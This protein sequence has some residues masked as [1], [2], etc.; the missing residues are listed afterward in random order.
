MSI[1]H[2]GQVFLGWSTLSSGIKSW[3]WADTVFTKRGTTNLC[4][5][6]ELFLKSL[7]VLLGKDVP[8]THK[9][10]ELANLLPKKELETV[11]TAYAKHIQQPSFDML[12]SEISQFFVKL[13]YEYEF[14]IFS[15]N[16]YAV[17]VF[18]DALYQHCAIRNGSNPTVKGVH[19]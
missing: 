17:C 3:A 8:K 12:L 18:A 4:F 11:R 13:R 1:Y 7:L 16:E 14:D 19:V 6:I 5:S 10:D 15:I 9:L 2:V